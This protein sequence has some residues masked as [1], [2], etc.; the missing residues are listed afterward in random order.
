[1]K[2]KTSRTNNM[3]LLIQDLQKQNSHL[4]SKSNLKKEFYY[5]I[6]R[7]KALQIFK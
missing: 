5:K 4:N 7:K 1:M 6:K 2:L 3:S